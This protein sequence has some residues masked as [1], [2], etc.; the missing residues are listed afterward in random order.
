MGL[1]QMRRRVYLSGLLMFCVQRRWKNLDN[2]HQIYFDS[3][4]LKGC[5]GSG[6]DVDAAE[7]T[8]GVAAEHL[9]PLDGGK[10]TGSASPCQHAGPQVVSQSAPPAAE[11]SRHAAGR[12]HTRSSLFRFEAV[13]PREQLSG[14]NRGVLKQ[15]IKKGEEEE[16]ENKNKAT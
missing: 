15:S 7:K 16:G 14:V 5:K 3:C 12:P 9:P 6:C 2:R 8:S 10:E 11:L 1:M 4:D 13:P